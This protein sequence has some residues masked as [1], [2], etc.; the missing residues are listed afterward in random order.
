[1]P[2]DGLLLE[3]KCTCPFVSSFTYS[4][5]WDREQPARYTKHHR[6][7]DTPVPRGQ[8]GAES[9]SQESWPDLQCGWCHDR[10]FIK[11]D[12]CFYI[13]LRKPLGSLSPGLGVAKRVWKRG[14]GQISAQQE[15]VAEGGWEQGS[16]R[17]LGALLRTGVLYSKRGFG[18]FLTMLH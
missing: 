5:V 17:A 2:V 13:L 16:C 6:A 14:L 4:S 1:M 9:H 7:P 8:D 18:G 15:L 12:T 10:P 3:P 11:A